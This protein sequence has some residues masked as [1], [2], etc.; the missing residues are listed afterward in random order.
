V[1]P[2]GTRST[3]GE[4]LTELELGAWQGM[5]RTVVA[6]RRELG[7]ALS[8]DHGLSMADYDLLVRLAEQPGGRMRMADLAKRI[9]QPKSSLTRIAS[10]LEGRGLIRREPSPD[11]RR[12]AEAVLTDA[13]RAAF[14]AAQRDH[15]G[16][17]RERFLDQL[18]DDQLA[19]LAE[20]W[21]AVS[22]S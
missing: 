6:L 11:D 3:E 9:L 22:P 19:D 4:P 5:L 13:G 7:E 10:G 18:D 14:H 15:L 8:A 2:N 21:R 12:G 20:V 1:I 16:R 17:V